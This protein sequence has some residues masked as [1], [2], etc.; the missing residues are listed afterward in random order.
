MALETTEKAKPC[1]APEITENPKNSF[2]MRYWEPPKTDAATHC[3][4]NIWSRDS[5]IIEFPRQLSI[6]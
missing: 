3:M 5:H 6:T 4:G 2:P 1:R